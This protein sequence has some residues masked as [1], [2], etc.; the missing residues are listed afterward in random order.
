MKQG[1]MLLGHLKGRA[2]EVAAQGED[3]TFSG[4]V[5]R[6]KSHSLQT[7]RKCS[8]RNS[9]LCRKRQVNL[10]RTLHMK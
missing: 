3:L 2:L 1:V 5:K 6:L 8:R 9:E 7:T 10:G 4:L